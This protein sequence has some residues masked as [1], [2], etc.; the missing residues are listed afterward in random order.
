MSTASSASDRIEQ[1]RAALDA[2]D[3][4]EH[5]GTTNAPANIARSGVA[6][7]LRETISPAA[8]D[9]TPEQVADEWLEG[10]RAFGLVATF[11]LDAVLRPDT[12]SLY[13]ES[14]LAGIRRG[15][16]MGWNSWEPETAPGVPSGT[17]EQ[18]A[19]EP[20]EHRFIVTVSGCTIS[21]ARQVISERLGHDEDYG[22]DYTLTEEEM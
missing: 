9:E 20:G 5:W 6:E 3:K 19:S 18:L 7:A 11:G 8:V 10:L 4:I 16:V 1:A 12:N 17:V 22:F 2:Y 14:Y 13:R 15:V 21:Q